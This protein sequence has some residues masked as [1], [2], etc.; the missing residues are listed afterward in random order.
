MLLK[1]I[2]GGA[3]WKV[4]K[5]IRCHKKLAL[6][7]TSNALHLRK[8]LKV[9][10]GNSERCPHVPKGRNTHVFLSTDLPGQQ[11]LVLPP[12]LMNLQLWRS[13][14]FEDEF[15]IFKESGWLSPQKSVYAPLWTVAFLHN[16]SAWLGIGV[17]IAKRAVTSWGGGNSTPVRI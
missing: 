4:P 8:N 7:W 16:T 11:T 3:D 10:F 17:G 14:H 15:H 5:Q 13:C 9:L 12:I 2:F 6:N 1:C